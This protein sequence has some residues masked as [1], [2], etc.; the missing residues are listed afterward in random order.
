MSGLCAKISENISVNCDKPIE[1]GVKDNIWII[2]YEDWEDAAIT[3]NAL[4]SQIIEDIVLPSGGFAY[5]MEGINNSP[6]PKQ[7]M[8]KGA[9]INSFSHEINYKLFSLNPTV[10]EQLELKSKS[11][12]VVIVENNY[13]GDNG[14]AAYEVYGAGSGL[15]CE[16]IERDPNSND[17]QGAYDVTLKTS[18]K[19]REA[20]LPATIF[21]TNY[22]TT[23]ALVESLAAA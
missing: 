16:A 18:E 6:A 2:N 11:R 8:V 4:N 10:K 17:T 9:F 15:V 19:S 22:A 7:S 1:G 21:I 5:K 14:E 3:K 23:K 20:H 13:K 12:V